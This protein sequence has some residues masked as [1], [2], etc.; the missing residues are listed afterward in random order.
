MTFAMV[1]SAGFKGR[2]GGSAPFMGAAQPLKVDA[3]STVGRILV[4]DRLQRGQH[5]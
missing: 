1:Q 2:Y 4:L 3:Y 5:Q